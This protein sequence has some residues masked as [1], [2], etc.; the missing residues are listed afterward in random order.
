[1]LTVAL[2]VNEELEFVEM[3]ERLLDASRA[4][5][6]RLL[7]LSYVLLGAGVALFGAVV[8]FS[9]SS[10]FAG[11][12]GVVFLAGVIL[13]AQEVADIRGRRLADKLIRDG[14]TK[15]APRD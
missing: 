3:A 1:M 11:T 14:F 13:N 4:W 5:H 9:W 2:S 15:V 7:L 6:R 8:W 12:A 10:F